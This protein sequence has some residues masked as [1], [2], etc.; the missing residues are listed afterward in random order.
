MHHILVID[1]EQIFL[2]FLGQTLTLMG[3]RVKTAN[4]GEGA[5]EI[6]RDD[7]DF[8]LVDHD[9]DLVITDIVMPNIDG[10]AVA[11]YI[12]SS[13]RADTPIVAITG[14]SEIDN[15]ELFNSILVKPFKIKELIAVIKSLIKNT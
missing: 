7:H 4:S 3:Y 13:N 5:I 10:N 2:G 1:D 11:E 9:F 8:D 12:R 6:L 14:H 15:K